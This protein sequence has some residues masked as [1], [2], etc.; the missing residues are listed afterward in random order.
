MLL[1]ESIKVVVVVLSGV[2]GHLENGTDGVG[3]ARILLDVDTAA[4]HQKNRHRRLCILLLRLHKSQ[5]RNR[6]GNPH[7]QRRSLLRF[8]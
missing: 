3:V 4:N 2:P 8:A 5:P 7:L 6:L 1:A